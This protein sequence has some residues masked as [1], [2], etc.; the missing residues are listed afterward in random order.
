M[1]VGCCGCTRILRNACHA[2]KYPLNSYGPWFVTSLGWE[3]KKWV[4]RRD[5]EET[6]SWMRKEQ[7]E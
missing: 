6:A 3:D 4:G 1:G 2:Q 5:V 7:H